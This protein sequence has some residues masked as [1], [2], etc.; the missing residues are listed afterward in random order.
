M[1]AYDVSSLPDTHCLFRSRFGF[2]YVAQ[3]VGDV[4][5]FTANS[6]Q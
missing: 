2:V 6:R 3:G 1:F 5:L 4:K